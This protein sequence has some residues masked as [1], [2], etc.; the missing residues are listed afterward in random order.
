[1]PPPRAC[2]RTTPFPARH[3]FPL[4]SPA[5]PFGLSICRIRSSPGCGYFAPVCRHAGRGHLH[6]L[7]SLRSA[8]DYV[9]GRPGQIG[10]RFSTAMSMSRC[11]LSRGAQEM[12]GGQLDVE[13]AWPN[14]VAE[15]EVAGAAEL[16]TMINDAIAAARANG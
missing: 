16:E 8:V 13:E 15:Y 11:R 14:Y 12:L 2:P 9:Y 4:R 5:L 3:F 7:A 6:F 1:M 10:G